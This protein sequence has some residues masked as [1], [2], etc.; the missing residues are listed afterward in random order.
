MTKSLKYAVSETERRRKMQEEY[1][2]KHDIT[3]QVMKKKVSDIVPSEVQEIEDELEGEDIDKKM[4]VMRKMMLE[5]AANLEFEKAAALR[6][7]I[8]KLEEKLL[9]WG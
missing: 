1:N 4:E 3:P 2:K 6:D 9:K 7:K 5:H 8:K